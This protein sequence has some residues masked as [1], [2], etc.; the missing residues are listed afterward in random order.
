LVGEIVGPFLALG[1]LLRVALFAMFAERRADIAAL[2]GAIVAGAGFDLLA[3]LAGSVP[4]VAL[5]ALFQLSWLNRRW[6]RAVALMPALF[7]LTFDVVVQYF[8]F[9]EY[10]ARYN[11]LA[12]DYLMYPDEVFGNI[13][14]SYNVPL[15]ASVAAG[16]AVA[17]AWWVLRRPPPVFGPWSLLDRAKGLACTA[18]LAATAW[19][20]WS[21]APLEFGADRIMREITL[22]GWA[23][24]V[25]AYLTSHL[26]Y[27]AYYAMLPE[28]DA[29]A[30]VAR[31]LRPA[32]PGPSLVRRFEPRV[33]PDGGPLDVVII[34]E[35]SLGSEYSTRFGGPEAEALTPDFDRWS[36]EGLALTNLVATGNRTVRGLEGILSSFVPLPGD[37]IVKRNK[38]ENVATI[39]RVLAENGYD[40]AF[41]YGGY[42]V[43]DSLKPFATANGYHEFFEQPSYPADAFRTIWGVADEFVFDALIERQ[44]AA[45]AAGRRF[46]GTLLTVSNHK[47]YDVPTGRITWTTPRAGRRGAVR[48]ADWSIGH[49]L[50][51][52]RRRALLDHTV[53]LIVGDHGARVYGAE[54]IPVGSYRI[55]AVFFTPEPSLRGR[56]IDRLTSQVDL[57][58]TLLSL[59][60]VAYDAPFFGEDLLD[61]ASTTSRA[62]VNHNR[63]IGLL[64]D[65]SLVVL[66]LNHRITAYTR[67][68]RSSNVF[69]LVAAPGPDLMDLAADAQ[70]VFQTAY[71]AYERE[72]YR[73]PR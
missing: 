24:L 13:F 62:Y 42:G 64:T 55:P 28:A 18:A 27:D 22:N 30:R 51:Q 15:W 9:E 65:T 48:Y 5:F 35:E 47:P 54:A 7:V 34:L 32:P 49:Y 66:G 23:Q 3:G 36:A 25:R 31:Q 33:Q 44:R 41:F 39:A 73:L 40:T 67:P 29:A 69:T 50:A 14:A 53:V 17:V 57:G 60:G 19:G 21:V 71:Q 20:A 2:G 45:K 37:A 10:N 16:A 70:A 4:I 58:P 1:A 38:S 56:T 63:D 11:H 68:N 61:P 26:D 6:V 8:F 46:F 43:F 12:L 72:G 52:A 59:A